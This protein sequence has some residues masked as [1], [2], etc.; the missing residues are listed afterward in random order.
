MRLKDATLADG[1]F[2]YKFQPD[3]EFE[4]KGDDSNEIRAII[5]SSRRDIYQ[6]RILPKALKKAAKLGTKSPAMLRE[7]R[8]DMVIGKWIKFEAVEAKDGETDLVATGRV[9]TELQ[10]AADVPILIREGI[11]KMTSIG[12]RGRDITFTKEGV[13][14]GAIEIKEASLVLFAAN[15]DARL[16]HD[17]DGQIDLKAFLDH[18]DQTDLTIREKGTIL[19]SMADLP[20]VS[21]ADRHLE[22]S[23]EALG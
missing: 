13:D 14:I 10:A 5:S 7:H 6:E 9:L 20:T 2:R 16:L 3:A 19:K 4:V 11:L 18:L 15:E 22:T 21:A 17:R 8:R 23:L 12:F 1:G